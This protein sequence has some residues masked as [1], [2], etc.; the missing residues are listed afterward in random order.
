MQ[1][2]MECVQHERGVLF[3]PDAWGNAVLNVEPSVGFVQ[4]EVGGD[5]SC[6]CDPAVRALPTLLTCFEWTSLLVAM[7]IQ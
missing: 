7:R 6:R 1:S 2:K 5:P 3:V 4:D